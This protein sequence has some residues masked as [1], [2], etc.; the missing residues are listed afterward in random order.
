MSP[1]I[2]LVAR[3]QRAFLP[4]SEPSR[5]AGTAIGVG[6][7]LVATG[8]CWLARTWFSLPEVVMVY[9]LVVLATSVTLARR[10]AVATAMLVV[11]AF[12]F[13]FVPPVFGFA[14]TDPR[15]LVTLIGFMT[16][17]LVVSSYAATVRHQ[18]VVARERERRTTALY[19]VSR[20]LSG[21]GDVAG[22]AG[23]VTEQ[24]RASLGCE[25]AVFMARGGFVE[26]VAG[27]GATFARAEPERAAAARALASGRPQGR[28]AVQ[29]ARE[30]ALH[31]P[32]RS[33]RGLHGVLSVEFPAAPPT[34]GQRAFLD[35]VAALAASALERT[36]LMEASERAHLRAA[37]ERTRSTLLSAIS[38]DLRT[39]LA[40][41]TGATGALLSPGAG[42]SEEARRRLLL[43]SHDESVRMGR[44]VTNLLDLARVESGEFVADKE[45]FPL[46]ELLASAMERVQP[47]L[48]GR[49][50]EASIP[51]GLVQ[52]RVDGVLVEQVVVN[53]LEN[54]AKHTPAGSPI[55]VR[56]AAEPRAIV[57]E[58]MD[59]GTGIPAEE[60]DRIFEGFHR[61]PQARD[62]EGTGLGLALCRAIV[63]AHGG[64]IWAENRPGG[65][66]TF[67][68]TLPREREPAQPP[69]E[70][71]A[72]AGE[73]A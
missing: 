66:A 18:G 61:L 24:V 34:F 38:H 20:A 33:A 46:E 67:R 62:S 42:L 35:A 13:F 54:A 32:L 37:A 39:P 68:F 11:A 70:A 2:P 72:A 65:G 26:P 53:L 6:C 3:L 9:V 58:V 16:T 29:G 59:R 56:V 40:S 14:P 36:S 63:R 43:A 52:V 8:I 45:W 60:I 27:G 41:I 25:A 22:V 4:R 50:I 51:E 17:S 19:V 49:R 69:E 48:D 44:L 47:R 12:D 31:L 30:V 10:E 5:A 21:T 23:V 71:R 7:V 15:H 64:R 1:R 57:V 73:D 55:E 28:G